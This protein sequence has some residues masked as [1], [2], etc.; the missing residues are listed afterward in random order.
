MSV[1]W[2]LSPR[3]LAWMTAGARIV[4]GGVFILSGVGKLLEPREEF[5]GVVRAFDLLP[6]SIDFIYAALLPW[7]ELVA[8]VLLALGL[9][10]RVAASVILLALLSFFIALDHAQNSPEVLAACGCFGVFSGTE[11]VEQILAR[12]LGLFLLGAWALVSP[13]DRFSLDRR[14]SA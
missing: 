11:T 12:D 14:L 6:H 7:V 2:F 1:F 5:L 3:A 9:F 10:R 13:H 8:G 4:L